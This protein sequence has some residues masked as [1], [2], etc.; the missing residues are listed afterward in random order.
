MNPPELDNPGSCATGDAL[1]MEREVYLAQDCALVRG[2]DGQR[3]GH[4][5]RGA[6]ENLALQLVMQNTIEIIKCITPSSREYYDSAILS[7]TIEVEMRKGHDFYALLTAKGAEDRDREEKRKT[8][9]R[10]KAKKSSSKHVQKG[11]PAKRSGF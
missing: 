6:D 2:P 4:V 8:G 10:K 1:T 9:N 5:R 3:L 7:F 11:T